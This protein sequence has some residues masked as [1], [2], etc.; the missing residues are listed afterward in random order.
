[1]AD[2]PLVPSIGSKVLVEATV[3]FINYFPSDEGPVLPVPCVKVREGISFGVACADPQP[4]WP[5]T[6]V[7]PEKKT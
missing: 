3:V 2:H 1:M 6:P 7:A 5:F 4:P